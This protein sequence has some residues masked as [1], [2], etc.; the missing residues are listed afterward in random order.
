MSNFIIGQYNRIH[1]IGIGGIGMSGLARLFLHE[2]KIVS[3]S[4]STKSANSEKLEKEGATIFYTQV[5]ENISPRLDLGLPDLVVYTEAMAQD[6]PELVKAQEMGIKTVNYFEA[7]GMVANEYYLIA[8]AGT[9]GKTTT[10]AML[11]DIFEEASFDPTAIVGSLRSKTGSNYRAGKSKYFIVEAC[12]YRRDFLSLTPDVLVITNIE[13]EH[14]DYYADLASVQKA[15]REF[16]VQVREGG[17]VVANITDPAVTPVL[18]GL[19]CA[20]MDYRQSLDTS[21]PLRQPGL[22]NRLNAAAAASAARFVGI[23]QTIITTALENF[24]GTAR[25]FEYKGDCNNA[26]VYDD[27]A[28]HPTEIRASIAGAR[29]LHPNKKLTI[30]F[31]PHTYS[32]TQ[33]LFADFVAELGKADRVLLVPIYAARKEEGYDISSSDIVQSLNEQGVDAESFM[34]LEACALEIK[35]SVSKNDVVLVMGAGDVGRVASLLVY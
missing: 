6:H 23:E 9:H 22:H 25:R 4:D 32:R 2:G 13:H 20:V 1:F 24:A 28:H 27:Y 16:A 8:V 26:P 21:L 3:G 30:V 31:Q 18:A 17:A 5:P 35:E 15:F 12:E 14:V 33:E 11:I 19:S 34:T 7:L 10:T 29:E